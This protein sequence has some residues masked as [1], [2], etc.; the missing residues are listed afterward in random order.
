MYTREDCT[1]STNV[2]H[3]YVYELMLHA[4]LVQLIKFHHTVI[5]IILVLLSV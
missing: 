1:C 2:I 5:V 4:N 3:I